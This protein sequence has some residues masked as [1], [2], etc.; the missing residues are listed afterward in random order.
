MTT[1][2]AIF[3][4]LPLR[5]R[6]VAPISPEEYAII[7]KTGEIKQVKANTA[8]EAFKMSGLTDAIRIERR[9]VIKESVLAKARFADEAA[10]LPAGDAMDGIGQGGVVR[11]RSPVVTAQDLD[12]MMRALQTADAEL[13]PDQEAPPPQVVTNPTGVEVHGDGFDELI[14]A[15][16]APVHAG[17]AKPVTTLTEAQASLIDTPSP[18]EL[19]PEQELSADEVNKLLNGQ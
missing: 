1:E 11:L 15:T 6:N 18:T 8:Y 12:M 2:Q 4:S 10:I 19:P 17:G 14:P 9:A 7:S 16:P 3:E 13:L 5:R